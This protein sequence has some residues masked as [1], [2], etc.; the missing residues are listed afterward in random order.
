MN[1]ALDLANRKMFNVSYGMRTNVKK[2]LLLF[3]DHSDTS[4]LGEHMNDIL[5]QSL[6]DA[7][8]VLEVIKK[9]GECTLHTIY[10]SIIGLVLHVPWLNGPFRY[11]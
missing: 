4:N 7:A 9:K 6:K 11:R 8:L 5:M 2:I 1:R 3:T 10:F